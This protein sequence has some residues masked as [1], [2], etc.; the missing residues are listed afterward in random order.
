M[1]ITSRDMWWNWF[2]SGWF[3]SL[4]LSLFFFCHDWLPLFGHDRDHWAEISGK[5]FG[6]VFWEIWNI[7]EKTLEDWNYTKKIIIN[8]TIAMISILDVEHKWTWGMGH[9][10][11]SYSLCILTGR[12]A[13]AHLLRPVG[14]MIAFSQA[15]G[16]WWTM[17]MMSNIC[18]WMGKFRETI[19]NAKFFIYRWNTFQFE[20]IILESS[21]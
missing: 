3:L 17:T 5:S 19:R 10:L 6:S 15:V 14:G 4:F 18:I 9:F 12:W 11:S 8:L 2:W 20:L 13:W 1:H 16:D 21:G 7:L